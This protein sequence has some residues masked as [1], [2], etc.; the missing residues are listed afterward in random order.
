MR[1]LGHPVPGGP[2]LGDSAEWPRHPEARVPASGQGVQLAVQGGD[3]A[4][5]PQITGRLQHHLT[6]P[7]GAALAAGPRNGS[8]AAVGADA[9]IGA[10]GREHCWTW[11]HSRTL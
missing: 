10:E 9:G 6:G 3:P 4:R 7:P 8:G 5:H 11:P 2:V 1:V